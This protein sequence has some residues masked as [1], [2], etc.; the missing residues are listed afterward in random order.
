MM[1]ARDK[2]GSDQGKLALS[3]HN[4]KSIPSNERE[5]EKLFIIHCKQ[6]KDNV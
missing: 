1:A 4:T 2:V 3:L 6:K 5:K